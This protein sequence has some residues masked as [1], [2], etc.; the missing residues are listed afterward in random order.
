MH[1]GVAPQT[2]KLCT[3]GSN[4]NADGLIPNGV[5]FHRNIFLR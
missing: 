4:R 2:S 5:D 3:I 1:I